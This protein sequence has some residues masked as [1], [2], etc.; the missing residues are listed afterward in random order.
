MRSSRFFRQLHRELIDARRMAPGDGVVVA[1]SGGCDSMS[2]LAGLVGVNQ[3]HGMGLRLV[4]AH[5]NHQTRGPDSDADARFVS[6]QAARLGLPAVIERADVPARRGAQG[7]GLEQAGRQARYDLFARVAREHGCRLVATAHHADDNAETILHRIIRGTGPRGLAG[8]GPVRP[9]AAD[10]LLPDGRPILLVRPLL[11]F[12]R[13]ALERFCRANDIPFRTDA[14]NESVEPTRNWLR[15]ELIPLLASRANPGVVPALLRLGELSGWVN[16]FVEE[17][18]RRT[19]ASL[20]IDRNDA[21]LT[22]NAGSLAGKGEIVQAEVI[23]QAM[24]LLGPREAEIGL[25][26]LKAVMRLAGNDQSGKRVVLPGSIAAHRAGQRLVLS[27]RGQPADQTF[28]A[29]AEQADG[30]SVQWPGRTEMPVRRKTLVV[31][32]LDNEPGL[33][34][35]F[36]AGKTPREELMDADRVRPPVVVRPRQ[37]GDRFWPLGASGNKKVGDFLTDHKTPPLLRQQ[38][39]V[40]CDQLGPIW[41]VPLRI[42][43]RVRVTEATQRVARVRIE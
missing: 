24:L 30:L 29:A 20:L 7:G 12:R 23:R 1:V 32:L 42:D 33:L 43:D 18:A 19:L 11:A 8:I 34:E 4:V 9:L 22:L 3:A 28:R 25:R 39:C 16:A 35:R 26:H 14:T 41:V 13:R 2:L 38:V 17:T 21:E 36:R 37:P 27:R 31:E 5:L 6:Q 10:A 40:L 15:H